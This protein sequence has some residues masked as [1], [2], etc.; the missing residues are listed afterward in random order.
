MPDEKSND[1]TKID[2]YDPLEKL[3]KRFD[4][5]LYLV[6]GAMLIGFIS[7]LFMVAGMV[8]EAWRFNSAV[9]KELKQLE[10]QGENIKNTV[11]QQDLIMKELQEIK[12]KLNEKKK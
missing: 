10:V 6:V 7:L 5:L 2:F 9:Y 3:K 11:E 12:K 8:I 4:F 1:K